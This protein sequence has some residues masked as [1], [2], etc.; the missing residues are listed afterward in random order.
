VQELPRLVRQAL[1]QDASL[2]H[3]GASA[4]RPYGWGAITTGAPRVLDAYL[5]MHLVEA[6]REQL[7]EASA[8]TPTDLESVLLRRVED[9]WPFPPHYQLAPQP[10]AAL[11]LLD[12]P[13]PASVGSD[14]RC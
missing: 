13:D 14:A 7:A 11:D 3:T 1:E 12:Y 2:V 8:T 9:P 10:L 5:S 6:L 4:A